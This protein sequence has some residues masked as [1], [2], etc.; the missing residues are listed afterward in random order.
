[1]IDMLRAQIKC[2]YCHNSYYKELYA[3][4]R[5]PEWAPIYKDGHFVNKDTTL[6]S[7]FCCCCN[8][9]KLFSYTK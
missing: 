7:V 8:C 6:T 2:P 1:M 5:N 9:G 3:V 4:S